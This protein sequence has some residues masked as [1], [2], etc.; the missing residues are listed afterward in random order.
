MLT[1]GNQRKPTKQQ[2]RHTQCRT[3]LEVLFWDDSMLEIMH[4]L[5]RMR[6]WKRLLL[7]SAQ[8]DNGK[9]QRLRNCAQN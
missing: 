3:E 9:F 8:I 6:S 4:K 2:T 1:P 5:Y 7:P